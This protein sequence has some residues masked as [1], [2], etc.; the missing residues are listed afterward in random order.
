MTLYNFFDSFFHLTSFKRRHYL[1]NNKKRLKNKDFS[2]ICCNCNGGHICHDLGLR[3]NSPFVN[4]RL[5]A[6]NFMLLLKNFDY[7]M[8]CD[9]KQFDSPSNSYPVGLL[10]DLI[11]HFVHYKTWD[12]VLEKWNR[13][14][15]RINVDNLFI[16]FADRYGC[17]KE[18]MEEFDNLPYAN[19]VLFTNKRHLPFKSCF[20][21]SGF[22]DLDSVDVCSKFMPNK[23]WYRY[24]DQF[25]FVEWFNTGKVV[26]QKGVD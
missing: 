21:I 9:L 1:K 10:G 5:N 3:F 26:R 12:E 15:E 8:N 23:P 20:Y 19:K 17:T 22:D 11:I 14:K 18:I 25:D 6:A 16:L 2:L 24:L 7:Y 4:L 13:R